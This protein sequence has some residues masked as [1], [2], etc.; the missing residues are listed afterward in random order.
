MS[1]FT[2]EGFLSAN[3]DEWSRECSSRHSEWFALCREFNQYC[4]QLLPR[5]AHKNRQQHLAVALFVR[6][7]SLFQSSIILTERCMVNETK[8]QLRAMMEALFTLRAITID[9]TMA[10]RYYDNNI[11]E[12]LKNLRRYKHY[13]SDALLKGLDLDKRIDE[14]D[15]MKRQKGIVPLTTE[16]LAK[17]AGLSD[18]YVS[19]YPVLSW[20]THSN[21]IDIGQYIHGKSDEEIEEVTWHPQMEG[22][23][24]LLLTAMECAIIGVRSVNELF[25]LGAGGE[26][27]K[28][29]QRYRELAKEL[30]TNEID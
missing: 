11:L 21:V 16:T 23:D 9:E 13:G 1:T 26:I 2:D 12:K 20:T 28:Y 8:I 15:R 7:L 27:E 22:V 18:F 6:L 5:L 30:T 25:S 24:K 19:A 10:E 4:M 17:K 3:M 14:L 29:S